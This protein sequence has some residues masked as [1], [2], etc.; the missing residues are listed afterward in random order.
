MLINVS[1]HIT[2]SNKLWFLLTPFWD[3]MYLNLN[4]VKKVL[5]SYL[6][7]EINVRDQ[8]YHYITLRSIIIGGYFNLTLRMYILPT[9]KKTLIVMDHQ[10]RL[11]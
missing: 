3:I 5:E 9:I 7:L 6:I 1:K 10:L 8:S 4:Y 2:H 11:N